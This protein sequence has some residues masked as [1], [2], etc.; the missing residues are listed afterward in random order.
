MAR[1]PVHLSMEEGLVLSAF[2]TA[3]RTFSSTLLDASWAIL[4][5][6]LQQKNTPSPALYLGK[7][8][9]LASLGN[10]QRAFCT[11]HEFETGYGNLQEQAEDLFSPFTSLN[12]SVV[13][14]FKIGFETLDSTFEASRVFEH[15]VSMGVKTNATSFT[16]LVDAHLINQELKAALSVIDEMILIFSVV[17]AMRVRSDIGDA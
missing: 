1:P 16:L 9:A 11:L 10:L 4:R 14:C 12:Q 7:I 3:R 15:L 6:S 5:Q 13:A 2:G 8:Y 17:N